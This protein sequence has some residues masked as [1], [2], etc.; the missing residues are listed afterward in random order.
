MTNPFMEEAIK[1]AQKAAEMGEVPVGAVLVKNE[2]ILCRAHNVTERE[3]DILAHAEMLVMKEALQK[4]GTKR[5][6][7]CSLYVT[8]E[9]CP[10]CTGAILLARPDRVYFGAYDP[11]AGACG[12][13]NDLLRGTS[14]DVYGGMME[15]PCAELLKTF[16]QSLR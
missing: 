6:T 12:G 15:A 4:L 9:P 3:Q 5:L 16:F 1:E 11:E 14:I 10:M 7:G 2:K 13:K 8:L